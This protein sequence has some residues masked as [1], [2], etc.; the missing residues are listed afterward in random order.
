MN[1]EFI[2]VGGTA[3]IQ[4]VNRINRYVGASLGE[5]DGAVWARATSEPKV[6]ENGQM[7][8][9]MIHEFVTTDGSTLST[10]DLAV[11]TPIPGSDEVRM[12][13]LRTIVAS[14]GKFAGR[15]DTFPSFGTHNLKTGQGV[16][17]FL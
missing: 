4:L 14:T 6:H 13:V 2:S 7:E 1:Q 8:F 15:Q 5:L 9:S 16:Q 10:D 11:A 3:V 17:R 12:Y